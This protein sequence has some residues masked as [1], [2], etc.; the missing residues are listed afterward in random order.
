[1]NLHSLSVND[2]YVTGL[3]RLRYTSSV[4][5]QPPINKNNYSIVKENKY[6]NETLFSHFRCTAFILTTVQ[7]HNNRK[8]MSALA[9]ALVVV[10]CCFLFV[11]ILYSITLW[12]L[13]ISLPQRTETLISPSWCVD[14][15]W[16]LSQFDSKHRH[17]HLENGD[18]LQ[19]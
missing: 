6:N 19:E 5:L 8:K 2:W 4:D 1:M 18:H 10:F 15:S 7:C 13:V 9:L 11:Y 14:T 3:F 16:P 17:L 12:K